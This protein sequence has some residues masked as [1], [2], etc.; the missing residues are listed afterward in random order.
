MDQT[1]QNDGTTFGR[2][3]NLLV[4]NHPESVLYVVQNYDF[5]DAWAEAT[6][7]RTLLMDVCEGGNLEAAKYL[8]QQKGANVHAQTGYIELKVSIFGRNKSKEGR[9]TPLFFAAKSGNSELIEYL[10][11]RLVNVNDRSSYGATPLMYAVDHEHLEATKTLI[12]LG[13]KV[14]MAMNT[15]L[16]PMELVDLGRYD[17]ISNAYRRAKKTGNQEILSVLKQAGARP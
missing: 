2:I 15:N 11:S 4:S 9:L 13:A 10:A 3:Q 14:N 17:E 8:I 12:A 1:P 16:T 5:G 6:D 7:G